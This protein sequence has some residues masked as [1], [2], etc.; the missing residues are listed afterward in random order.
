VANE[1]KVTDWKEFCKG[2]RIRAKYGIKKIGKQE[3]YFSITGEILRLE[4]GK[5]RTYECGCI[6]DDISEHF[7]ELTRLIRWHLFS[8][9]TGPMH[10]VANATFWWEIATGIRERGKFDPDVIKAFAS[11]VVLGSVN[12][13]DDL[14][15][16][17][18]HD[19]AMTFSVHGHRRDG[20][21]WENRLTSAE[22]VASFLSARLPVLMERFTSDMRDAGVL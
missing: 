18:D 19:G 9:T 17:E 20:T 13:E 4:C 14:P 7:P 15:V 2:K 5:W 22:D 12:G 3:P 8:A 21:P 6:H 16:V 11:T 10:Y 1:M